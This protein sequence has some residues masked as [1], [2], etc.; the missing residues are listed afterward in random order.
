MFKDTRNFAWSKETLKYSLN[1]NIL[2]LLNHMILSQPNPT[3]KIKVLWSTVLET[4]LFTR[5]L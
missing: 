1:T 3:N 5:I 2:N 4:L